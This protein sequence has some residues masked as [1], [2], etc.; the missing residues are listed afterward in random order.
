[1]RSYVHIYRC[2][3]KVGMK[4]EQRG[5]KTDFRIDVDNRKV[6]LL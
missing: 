5:L 6:K 1:M 4:K 2:I 3:E